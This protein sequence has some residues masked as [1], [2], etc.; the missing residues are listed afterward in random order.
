MSLCPHQLAH[1]IIRLGA[2]PVVWAQGSNTC[3][4]ANEKA[5]CYTHTYTVQA[6]LHVADYQD[7][8]TTPPSSVPPATN[9][10]Y[11]PVFNS[12]GFQI[13]PRMLSNSQPQT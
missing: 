4:I 6:K 5:F 8:Q 3:S 1:L 7:R 13:P 10:S 9:P 11:V 2:N 12:S